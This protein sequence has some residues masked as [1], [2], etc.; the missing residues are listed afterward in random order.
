MT[1]E[2][3]VGAE[4]RRGGSGV[5]LCFLIPIL[6]LYFDTILFSLGRER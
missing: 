1:R 6:H 5:E 2:G 4:G 3:D